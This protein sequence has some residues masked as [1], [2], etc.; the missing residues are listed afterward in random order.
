M[1]IYHI[2]IIYTYTQK[3][4]LGGNVRMFFLPLKYIEI[5]SKIGIQLGTSR[6]EPIKIRG[7]TWYDQGLD[8]RP[9]EDS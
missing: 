7:M 1:N 5:P 3:H 4:F 2:S 6:I 9:G 8:K